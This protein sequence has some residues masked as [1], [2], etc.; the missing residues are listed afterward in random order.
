M[1]L[2]TLLPNTP[3]LHGHTL[4]PPSPTLPLHTSHLRTPET[5]YY[6]PITHVLPSLLRLI[7]SHLTLPWQSPSPFPT[8][9]PRHVSYPLQLNPPSSTSNHQTS[10]LAYLHPKPITL[11]NTQVLLSTGHLISHLILPSTRSLP[12]SAY[13][14]SH[15]VFPLNLCTLRLPVSHLLHLQLKSSHP[16]SQTPYSFPTNLPPSSHPSSSI[17]PPNNTSYSLPLSQ[18]HITFH[19]QLYP[20]YLPVISLSFSSASPFP[21]SQGSSSHPIAHH[22]SLP[23]SFPFLPPL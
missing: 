4:C 22:P 9:T 1:H 12:L 2:I 3:H 6:L 5:H 20:S 11:P 15:T 18:H 10:H 14:P 7:F 19:L 13:L 8:Y 23:R 16:P 21:S 17:S